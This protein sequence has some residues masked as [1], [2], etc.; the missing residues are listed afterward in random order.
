MRRTRTRGRLRR[1]R[2]RTESGGSTR[3]DGRRRGDGRRR[4]SGSGGSVRRERSGNGM[5]EGA[6]ARGPQ[7]RCFAARSLPAGVGMAARRDCQA[8]IAVRPPAD[9]FKDVDRLRATVCLCHDTFDQVVLASSIRVH[10]QRMRVGR[11]TKRRVAFGV[12]SKERDV[13]SRVEA[14]E[15]FREFESRAYRCPR[16]FGNSY[17]LGWAQG[18]VPCRV[19][20][21]FASTTITRDTIC[22]HR[23][24]ASRVLRRGVPHGGPE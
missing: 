19:A 3:S 16:E 7:Y 12:G 17:R 14:R 20:G 2:T 24:L 5:R 22:V 6:V 9:P 13:E 1:R 11:R 15:R 8:L 18:R 10:W 4:W 23:R 21:L